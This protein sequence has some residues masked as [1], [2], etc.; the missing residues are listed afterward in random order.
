MNIKQI[1]S[2]AASVSSLLLPP[3]FLSSFPSLLLSFRFLLRLFSSF[4]FLFLSVSS[5][6]IS[7]SFSVFFSSSFFSLSFPLSLSFY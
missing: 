4:S 2:L 5:S 1:I 3:P 6:S 7:L